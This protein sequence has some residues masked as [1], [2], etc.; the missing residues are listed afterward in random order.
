MPVLI[1]FLTI[2]A[3]GVAFLVATLVP[4]LRSAAVRRTGTRVTGSVTGNDIKRVGN[5][6]SWRVPTVGY[7]LD[8]HRYDARLANYTSNAGLPEGSAVRL[9]V[10]PKNP[11]RPVAVELSSWP[12]VYWCLI[13]IAVGVLGALCTGIR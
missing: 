12:T 3:V 11:Y 13:P 8:G 4:I 5:G 1:M 9:A 6:A 7:T 10:S 2:A